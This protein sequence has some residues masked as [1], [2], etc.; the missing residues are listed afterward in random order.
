MTR[1][2]T[3]RLPVVLLSCLLI[4]AFF[5]HQALTADSYY[6]AGKRA[7]SARNYEKAISYFQK[8]YRANPG[9][10]NALY[11]I[12]RI[13]DDQ[14]RPTRAISFYKQAVHLRMESQLR[15][16]ALWKV[17]LY[18]K[19]KKN[20][21]ELL[22]Y[23]RLFLRYKKNPRVERMEALAKEK[24]DPVLAQ[25]QRDMEKADRYRK[26]RK[27][28][29]A[30]ELYRGVLS[31]RPDYHQ[32]RWNLARLR[33]KKGEHK[34]ALEHFRYLIRR[35]EDAWDYRYKSAVCLYQLGRYEEASAELN[36][37]EEK[38]K[39]ASDAFRYHV[40]YLRGR[41]AL[42]QADFSAACKA[43][44][45]ARK[46]HPKRP[47]S[48]LLSALALSL[49]ECGRLKEAH[50]LTKQ[51]L[52]K[53]PVL[54]EALLAQARLAITRRQ[55]KTAWR[56]GRK[57]LE[58]N[59]TKQSE[60]LH[61]SYTPL[62]FFLGKQAAKKM[63]YYTSIAAFEKV[64][65]SFLTKLAIQERAKKQP[66][67]ILWD[68]N[69]YYGISLMNTRQ[70]TRALH[71]LQRLKK[72]DVSY[73]LLA[74]VYALQKDLSLTK[75]MILKSTELNPQ[76]WQRAESDPPF[77]ALMRENAEF[78]EFIQSRNKPR[79]TK[80]VQDPKKIPEKKQAD[81]GQR[82]TGRADQPKENKAKR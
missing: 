68:F 40:A 8:A 73:Y 31:R 54:E 61:W 23:S 19:Y 4:P 14:R 38:N 7:Y 62:F 24:Y 80:Q 44:G 66:K 21:E 39:N 22:E 59:K 2:P 49:V 64:R 20:W 47:S 26:E 75:E 34:R 12:G 70:Y 76:C 42:E 17:L 18:L 79:E 77:Q 57:L 36:A 30:I 74:R 43:L 6:Q 69:Y 50:D 16:Q 52:K 58:A 1:F 60:D 5:S 56:L 32:A 67:D 13:Y 9:S 3:I 45:L 48:K 65:T 15:E 81:P 11:Y 33:M 37:A 25:I 71:V 41:I 82:T 10:G 78:K 29:N 27:Y 28:G 51:A 53:R 63:H 46:L 35:H 72:N 55:Y